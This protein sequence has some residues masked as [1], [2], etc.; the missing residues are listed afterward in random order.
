[1]GCSFLKQLLPAYL[2]HQPAAWDLRPASAMQHNVPH[3]VH[4]G[5]LLDFGPKRQLIILHLCKEATAA[6]QD[7]SNAFPA[8]FWYGPPDE[9]GFVFSSL[10]NNKQ[11]WKQLEI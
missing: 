6:L 10:Q 4:T 5:L 11:I 3:G 9:S 2:V 7:V 1:M 8:L